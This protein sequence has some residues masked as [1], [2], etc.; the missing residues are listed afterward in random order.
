MKKLIFIIICVFALTGVALASDNDM[1]LSVTLTDG[2][3]FEANG[4]GEVF[5]PSYAD[6][7]KIVFNF[8]KTGLSYFSFDKD[9]KVGISSGDTIDITAHKMD[10][11]SYVIAFY[12]GD[13]R[14]VYTLFI[15]SLP[16]VHITTSIGISE[17]LSYTTDT[18]IK[19]TIINKNGKYEYVDTEHMCGELRIRGN[20]TDSYAKRPFQLKLNEKKNLFG[21]GEAK[22]WILLANYLDQSFIRNSVMY[23]LGS[24]LG[25]DTCEFQNIDLFIDG[26]YYG[27][28]TLCE[29][30]QIGDSR[31]NINDLEK[32]T[33]KLNPAYGSVVSVTSGG[34]INKGI[35]REYRYVDGVIDPDDITGGYIVEL[36]NNNYSK[37]KCYF[38]TSAGN[39]Y[40]VKSPENTSKAQMEYIAEIFGYM[41]SALSSGTGYNSLGKHY[42]EYIDADSLAYAYIMAEFGRNYDAGSSS[43]F[44]YKD[45]DTDGNRTK[46]TS[47]PL[48]DCDNT[49]GNILKGGASKQEGYWAANRPFWNLCVKN[50]DFNSLVKKHFERMYDIIYD[51]VDRG[52]Y[53]DS[54]V[55]ELGMSVYMERATWH[56]DI[57]AKWPLY[58]SGVHYDT[59]QSSQTFKFIKEYSDG[60]DADISTVIGYLCQC[61][62]DRAEW[63]ASA[64]NC[65]VERR[66]RV[67]YVD[68]PISDTDD[69]SSN[70]SDTSDIIND[71]D[72]SVIDT[73]STDVSSDDTSN[74][75]DREE[76]DKLSKNGKIVIIALVSCVAVVSVVMAIITK[77]KH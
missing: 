49:L 60:V 39:H 18:D 69:T 32:E 61:M 44:F 75:S 33:D 20:T 77:K 2:R 34:L 41:E 74:S 30:V 3:T 43:T 71:T 36:D 51:M 26:K 28:Y 15:S 7:S 54:L 16:S 67:L 29:K 9:K 14:Y 45:S 21:M 46:I 19:T 52:G 59:W 57:Y 66:E 73:S 48:W 35:L 25:M 38:V 53:I 56:S 64:W 62:T 40:V 6:P 42:S 24:L 37:E 27:V 23:K 55:D 22:T 12:E 70:N 47:G 31:I 76:A 50:S 17:I 13:E 11:G 65:D 1:D 10:D 63:L 58:S 68:P 5:L 8:S 4:S 72:S